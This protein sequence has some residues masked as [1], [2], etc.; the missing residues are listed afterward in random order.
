MTSNNRR[1]AGT[2]RLSPIDGTLQD[3]E[4]ARLTPTNEDYLEAIYELSDSQG[5]VRS[6]DLAQHIGVSKASV[7]RAVNTLKSAGL[8]EQQHYGSISL[9]AEGQQYASRILLRHLA[10]YKFLK[11]ILG[12]EADTAY[13][14]ACL[15][16]HSISVETL[17]KLHAHVLKCKADQALNA[18]PKAAPPAPAAPGTASTPAAPGQ[19]S[20]IPP[21]PAAPGQAADTPAAPAPAPAAPGQAPGTQAAQAAPA[22]AAVIPSPKA[23]D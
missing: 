2:P 9:T 23:N 20:D 3:I 16:E 8:V 14:E 22:A 17:E 6:V 19:A 11:E 15:M 12:V 7:N 18:D 21:A 5:T 13:Y 1:A 4:S 10:L